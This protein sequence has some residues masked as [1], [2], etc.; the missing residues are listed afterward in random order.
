M[1]AAMFARPIQTCWK[2]RKRMICHLRIYLAMFLLAACGLSAMGKSHAESDMGPARPPLPEIQS[3]QLMPAELTLAN[4]RDGRRVLVTGIAAD[5]HAFDLTDQASFKADSADLVVGEAGYIAPAP[6]ASGAEATVTVSAAGK[7]AT[8]KVKIASREDPPVRFVRDVEPLLSQVGCTAGTCHGAAKGKNGFK[9]SLRG[10]DPAYDYAALVQDLLGRRVNRVQPE[11]SLMLLKPTGA[12]PHE[13]RTLF[14]PG[15]RPYEL[16]VNWIRQGA[17][18][19]PD[20]AGARP[21][22]V[23]VIPADVNLDLP[24]RTQQLTVIAHYPDGS[25]RDVTRESI[26]S[27]NSIE[28]AKVSGNT[29]TALRRG[30]AAVLVRYE[31]NYG[32][33]TISIMGDRDGFV[34]KPMPE[35]NYIDKHVNAKLAKMKILPSDECTDDEFLR[36]VYLDL[37]GIVPTSDV[38]RR[39][40]Q[41]PSP[42]Q[43]KRARLVDSLLGGHDYVSFWSNRWADLLQCNSKTLGDKGVWL[44]REW[45]RESVAQNKPYDQFV[46]QLITAQGTE[47]TNP[48]V[49]YYRTLRETGK[50]TEDVSQ[51]FLGVRFNCNKC[52]DHPFERWTQDQYY[53]FG[54]F[55]AR[56]SFKGDPNAASEIVYT[57]YGGGEVMHPRTGRVMEPVVP[58]GAE[59]DLAHARTRQEAFASW[60]TSRENPLFARSY[61]NRVWSYFYGRGII[62]PVDDI[63]ASNPPCNPE[64]LDALTQDFIAHHFDVEH[65]IRTIVLSRTYQLSVIPNRWNEDD[66]I[67]FSHAIPRRLSAEQLRDAVA[68]ATGTREIT[69]GLPE[70]MRSVEMADGIVDDD[71]LKLF[72]RPK[73]ESACECERTSNVSLAHALS[74]VNGPVINNAVDAAD[75]SIIRLVNKE[76]DNRKVVAEIYYAILNRPPT[77]NELKAIDLGD[78]PHRLES[79]QDLAWALLNS[80]AFLFNR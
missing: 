34:F 3:L 71:F 40:A 12:V 16:I 49:N 70:G 32:A 52:H 53:Q 28:V 73:R 61:V 67:N 41:D 4:L 19:D 78:G 18:Y 23:E 69:Q 35:Y 17:R 54:A 7:Q 15:S 48:A 9:L 75:S 76:P 58:Y 14:H 59:P 29:V 1:V 62:E 2:G 11:M 30:E 63:R 60:L 77:E 21:D 51:T 55:F 39:F 13:G 72:G 43:E 5:G 46:H 44:F 10:Y 66:R 27:S 80:P 65:L 38:A 33:V 45:I 26:L 68:I 36:R 8:L 20:A 50:I 25:T 22:R 56:V 74:L 47:R 79:S 6:N 64:L 42:S 57:N 31:G 24:G 37:T